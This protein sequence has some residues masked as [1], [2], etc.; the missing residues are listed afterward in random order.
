MGNLKLKGER[1]RNIPEQKVLSR[2]KQSFRP[3]S[4]I[5]KVIYK[6]N[7]GTR[8]ISEYEFPEGTWRTLFITCNQVLNVFDVKEVI[9]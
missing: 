6:E 3:Q 1:Q 4:T 5:C 8:A 2:P 7:S 9:G